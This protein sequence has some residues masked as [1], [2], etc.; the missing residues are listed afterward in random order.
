MRKL[1]LAGSLLFAGAAFAQDDPA[2]KPETTTVRVGGQAQVMDMDVG[3]G[4]VRIV[5]RGVAGQPA[6]LEKAMWLGV[7][8]STLPPDA[9]KKLDLP[10]GMG[11]RVVHVEPDSPAQHAGVAVQDV[12]L[13]INDQQLFNEAQLRALI[14]TFKVDD[15]VK[16]NIVRGDEPM[17][18]TAKLAEREMA[19]LDDMLMPMGGGMLEL[20]GFP[21]VSG[22]I[23]I[24][25]AGANVE[26]MTRIDAD[27]V[28]VQITYDGKVRH[29]KATGSDGKLLF[30]GP[31]NTEEQRKAVPPDLL[32]RVG[33]LPGQIAVLDVNVAPIP[34]MPGDRLVF[35]NGMGEQKIDWADGD[36][37]LTLTIKRN[38]KDV[39]THLLVKDDTGKKLFDGPVDTREQRGEVPVNLQDKL[40][41]A[42]LKN[43]Q[44]AGGTLKPMRIRL[45]GQPG[46]Q[47]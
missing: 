45:E 3:N 4:Q 1:V 39:T 29:L 34:G 37:D 9:R 25:G 40:I 44:E 32:K 10:R 47:K 36:V 2:A 23:A 42:L 22:A 16:L 38:G 12:L 21:G 27:G 28:Q 17:S 6:K 20:P 26:N 8:C 46:E 41:Q 11:L 18:I 24:G 30:D 33:E 43:F 31:I 13:R 15:E 14:R 7:A 19:V 5:R 35:L